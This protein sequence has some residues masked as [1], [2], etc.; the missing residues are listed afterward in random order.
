MCERLGTACGG[1]ALRQPP[2][3]RAR[4]Y[5]REVAKRVRISQ[6][7]CVAGV[8]RCV[9]KLRDGRPCGRT[10]VA[11]SEF[12]VHHASLVEAHGD[13]E[14]KAG[15]PRRKAR[16]A[17]PPRIV[18]TE[19]SGTSLKGKGTSDPATVRPRLAEAAA[20]GLTASA[21][22]FSMPRLALFAT[23]GSRSSVAIVGLG[24]EFRSPSLTSAP[25]W[26]RSSSCSEKGLVGR[27]RRR[28]LP[29]RVCRPLQPQS[30]IWIGKNCRCS[31][32]R[33]VRTRSR[34]S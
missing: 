24:G 1:A 4:T 26:P 9:A 10:A 34:R 6:N 22:L 17:T 27:H 28:S 32:R 18:T 23:T 3:S 29:P 11:E 8:P 7:S 2:L 19:S 33:S 16:A 30:L 5:V 31:P 13:S 20:E 15:L 25:V 12:C 21:V 14:L